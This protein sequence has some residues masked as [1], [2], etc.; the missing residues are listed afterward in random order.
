MI[1]TQRQQSAVNLRQP[2]APVLIATAAATENTYRAPHAHRVAGCPDQPAA[3]T[4]TLAGTLCIRPVAAPAPV[5]RY[6]WPFSEIIG[7]VIWGVIGRWRST[8]GGGGHQARRGGPTRV[9]R[10]TP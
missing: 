3:V 10:P 2:C 7:A 6:W 1:M 5:R 9:E 8:G 4:E